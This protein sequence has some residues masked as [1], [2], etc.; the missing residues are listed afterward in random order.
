MKS[1]KSKNIYTVVKYEDKLGYVAF[2][3]LNFATL[4]CNK[5]FKKKIFYYDF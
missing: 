2:K 4:F 1:P 5:L 3:S